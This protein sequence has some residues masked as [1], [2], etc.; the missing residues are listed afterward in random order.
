MAVLTR[1]VTRV[2]TVNGDPT[3]ATIG[4]PR[5]DGTNGLGM[6]MR[7]RGI[8]PGI[9]LPSWLSSHTSR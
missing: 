3:R 7:A 4:R 8:A 2:S 9:A 5:S 6:S 1:F